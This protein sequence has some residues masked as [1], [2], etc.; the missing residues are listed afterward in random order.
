M[1]DAIIQCMTAPNP[2]D[3]AA[4]KRNYQHLMKPTY[5]LKAKCRAE[6]VFLV[7]LNNVF[8]Y[9]SDWVGNYI[10]NVDNCSAVAT[11]GSGILQISAS[12]LKNLADLDTEKYQET[13]IF[14]T[15]Y[16]GV[17]TGLLRVKYGLRKTLFSQGDWTIRVKYGVNT[18]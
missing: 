17:N 6:T 12:K 9:S 2:E 13:H 10:K 1:V 18:G 8:L 7:D 16:Y 11:F 3:I 4:S 5:K 14:P 15:G